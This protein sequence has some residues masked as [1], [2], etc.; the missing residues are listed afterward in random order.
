MTYLMSD[1]EVIDRIF[2]HVDNKTT[3]MGEII[4]KEPVENY[5]SEE[6]FQQELEVLRRTPVAFCPSAALP[7]AGSYIARKAAGR[8]VLV[9]RG[10][11]GIVRAFKNSCRHRGMPVT[12]ENEGC[13]RA[14]VCPYHAWTYGLDGELKHIPGEEGFPGIDKGDHGLVEISA[15]EK[16]GLVFV[17]QDGPISEGALEAMPEMLAPEQEYFGSIEFTD[18]ANWKLI[19][20]TS[21]EGYHIKSLHNKSFYPYGM[22]NVNVVETFGPN[23]RITFPF[24]RIEKLRDIPREERRISGMVT[25]VNQ[26]FPNTHMS[27]LSN[28]TLVI[29]LEPI[30]PSE[31]QWIFYRMTNKAGDGPK[32]SLEEIKKDVEFVKDVGLIEDREAAMAIQSSLATEANSHFTFGY[33]E[34]GIVHFHK[35]LDDAISKL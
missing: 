8:P 1:L 6:R 22:D 24:R 4:W 29:I 13:S 28:H 33:N 14:F 18:P 25:Y 31:T 7:E 35:Y 11:D 20:E 9:V 3:D 12:A 19:A 23:F 16:G 34:S 26:I 10:D 5:Q 30:S 2:D 17:T 27:V 32:K 21:M 15:V